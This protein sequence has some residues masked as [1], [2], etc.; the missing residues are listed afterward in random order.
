DHTRPFLDRLPIGDFLAK[1]SHEIHTPLNAIV[2]SSEM[3]ME[4]RFG[5]IG[6][7][8]YRQQLMEIHSSGTQLVSLI[9]DLLDL[10]NIEARKRELAFANVSLNELTQQCIA[11]MQPQAHRE[12]VII[13]SS[14]SPRL[15]QVTADAGS[16]RQIVLNLLSNSIKLAVAGGQVIVSTAIADTGE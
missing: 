15:P 13:R 11:I 8:R 9:N 5:P 4:E 7:Q 12:R 3:M 1:L 10:S 14:L 2:T 16:L 6:N